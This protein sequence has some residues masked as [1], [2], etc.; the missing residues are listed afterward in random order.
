MENSS[1]THASM[2][3]CY[4]IFLKQIIP[5]SVLKIYACADYICFFY[6]L[7]RIHILYHAKST[8]YK[9]IE[10][11]IHVQ[12]SCFGDRDMFVSCVALNKTM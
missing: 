7:F 4:T 11:H 3:N 2:L 5:C 6:V 1:L 12:M 10:Q 9:Y 8:V